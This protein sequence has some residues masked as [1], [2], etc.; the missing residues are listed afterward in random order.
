M[1]PANVRDEI[2]APVS[3]TEVAISRNRAHQARRTIDEVMAQA[4]AR[5]RRV[6]PHLAAFEMGAGA[7]L[8]DTR[9]Q[10]QREAG[11]EVSGALLVERN[12][13]EWRLDPA[14]AHRLP[15]VTGYE[16]RVIVMC[17]QGYSSVLA[18]LSLQE[19]GLVNATDV[20]GGFEAWAHAGLPII[21]GCRK[22]A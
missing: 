15:Q 8:V 9:S 5:L 7:L 2:D 11:G 4:S 1:R 16:M 21:G 20:V 14:S 13:L 3:L 10:A 19:L 18:A 6:G 17:A 22:S 12:V